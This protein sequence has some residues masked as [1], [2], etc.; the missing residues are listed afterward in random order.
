M[1]GFWGLRV[2]LIAAA[3]AVSSAAWAGD[4]YYIAPAQADLAD[5]LA[6]PPAPGSPAFK[7][8]L[9]AVLAAVKSRTEAAIA[10]ARADDHKI[11]FR[12]ADVMGPNFTRKTFPS[13]RSS[14]STSTRTAT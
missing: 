8:D 14:S 12:F 9:R 11:V 2:S 10:H 4:P 7:A 13:R 1:S 5:I 6:P 3:L